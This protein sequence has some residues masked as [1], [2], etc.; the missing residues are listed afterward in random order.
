MEIKKFESFIKPKNL[1][2]YSLD[3]SKSKEERIGYSDDEISE[4]VNTLSLLNNYSVGL[5]KPVTGD[6]E[7][8][9]I[10]TNLEDW[11]DDG[12]MNVPDRYE[13][14]PVDELQITELYDKIYKLNRLDLLPDIDT[15]NDYCLALM[16]MTEVE[17]TIILGRQ[18]KKGIPSISLKIALPI[19]GSV[20]NNDLFFSIVDETRDFVS[21]LESDNNIEIRIDSVIELSITKK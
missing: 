15:I 20:T 11:F 19:K 10:G 2:G 1:F 12:F 17:L 16:D 8:H 18:S 4:I 13:L 5:Q 6:I 21:Q 7:R 14:K 9:F 3:T